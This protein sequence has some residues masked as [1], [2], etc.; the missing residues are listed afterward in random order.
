MINNI[1]AEN[2][3]AFKK[4][5][6]KLSKI[7]L[8]FGPNN[9][10]KSSL[11]SLLTLL[12]QTIKSPD[13]SVPLLLQ[14]DKE[15]LGTYSDV[16][17]NHTSENEMKIG[18]KVSYPKN[19]ILKNN[20]QLNI[21]LDY[22]YRP[23]RHEIILKTIDLEYP[24]SDLKFRV[25]RTKS[26]DSA[27]YYLKQII[28]PKIGKPQSKIEVMMDH[29]VPRH[30]EIPE[31]LPRS[32]RV[33][34][35][36]MFLSR[37]LKSIKFIGPF[38]LPPQRIYTFS[39]EKS[40]SVGTRGERA[41]DLMI[42]DNLSRKTSLKIINKVIQWFQSCDIAQDISIKT[43]SDRYFE[44][45]IKK[46]SNAKT[47]ENIVDVGYG[48]S[49]VL[50][51]LIEGYNLET[52]VFIVQEP[53]IHL[54]PKAQAELGTFFYE[55]AQKDIQTI[56]ETHS[57]HLL[58]RLQA[59]IA[60]PKCNL[61]PDDVCVYYVSKKKGVST[62][63]KLELNEDGRFKD[64]WPEGFFPERLNEIMKIAKGKI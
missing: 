50:P 47:S 40:S 41:I 57:E 6:L 9:S 19:P 11:I 52:G 51:V 13:L 33:D 17:F 59:Y 39:G 63:D 15:D 4:I 30:F 1:Y 10:G 43:F 8:F 49:Q 26:Y 46:H 61:S 56:I 31:I 55:L 5:D 42:M 20:N 34:F 25:E 32:S 44:V 18:L 27:N 7:N 38:R 3:R 58:L 29:F 21:L 54:H 60:D 14:G 53:E 45:L 24:Q 12:S 22:S 23:I 62:Y 28:R 37:E 36:N 16:I 35:L 64:E 2:F 48:C